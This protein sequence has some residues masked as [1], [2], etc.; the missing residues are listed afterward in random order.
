MKNLQYNKEIDL[1]Q[2]IETY[3]YDVQLKW[4]PLMQ[5][6][7]LQYLGY[8]SNDENAQNGKKTNANY[9]EPSL[10]ERKDWWKK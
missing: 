9:L 2:Q 7:F 4:C 5:K 10:N 6:T 8:L 1:Q 3:K